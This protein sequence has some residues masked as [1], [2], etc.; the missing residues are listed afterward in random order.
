M[1]HTFVS[2]GRNSFKIFAIS[3]W[4]LHWKKDSDWLSVALKSQLHVIEVDINSFCLSVSQVFLLR[5][6]CVNVYTVLT[7]LKFRKDKIRWK[8]C[9]KTVIYKWKM[10]LNLRFFYVNFHLI[11]SFRNFNVV[12]TVYTF[13]QYMQ[14]K[15]TRETDRQKELMFTSM[16]LNWDFNATDS[17]SE[18]FFQ[19]NLHQ[20]MAN[21]LKEFLPSDT[22][23][24]RMYYI[25][26]NIQSRLSVRDVTF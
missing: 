11:L 17:Q 18:S 1:R 4:R 19:C 25:F 20:E 26:F 8:Y 9:Q 15:K 14:S 22:N 16:T 5:M 10:L 2:E 6:Y 3:W 23:V 21:I 7:P 12:S 13:A 24:Y